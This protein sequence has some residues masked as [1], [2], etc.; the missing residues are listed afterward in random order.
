MNKRD[1]MMVEIEKAAHGNGHKLRSWT[2]GRWGFNTHC[3]N[4]GACV[5]ITVSRSAQREGHRLLVKCGSDL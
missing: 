5:A 2:K 3:A 4:C 1:K